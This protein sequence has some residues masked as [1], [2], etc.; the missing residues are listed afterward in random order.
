[1]SIGVECVTFA[2][3]LESSPAAGNSMSPL[4]SPQSFPHLWKKLWKFADLQG[5]DAQ[6]AGI[7]WDFRD[8][9]RED[10]KNPT[11]SL[12]EQFAKTRAVIE[13]K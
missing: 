7:H 4:V 1:V 10:V 5:G 6:E 3:L 11:D 2:S 9:A 8:L 13:K 12:G